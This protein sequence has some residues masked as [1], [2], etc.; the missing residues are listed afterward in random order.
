MTSF[1][2]RADPRTIL[3]G[4]VDRILVVK[5]NKIVGLY[6]SNYNLYHTIDILK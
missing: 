6:Q 2:A 4:P 1:N 5:K 3:D